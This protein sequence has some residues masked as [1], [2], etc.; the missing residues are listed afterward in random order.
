MACSTRKS[1]REGSSAQQKTGK[2][3]AV[4]KTKEDTVL[5]KYPYLPLV[6]IGSTFLI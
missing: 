4:K 5:L 3:S 1:I 6:Y 2:K